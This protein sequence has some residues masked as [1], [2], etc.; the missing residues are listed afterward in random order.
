[1]P[2]WL[3]M[4]SAEEIEDPV[5][6]RCLAVGLVDISDSHAAALARKRQRAGAPHPVARTR[7]NDRFVRKSL[8]HVLSP[9]FT[10]LT[11]SAL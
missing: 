4:P 6:H 9:H 1:M 7:D 8:G 10:G 3:R 2:C 5:L 11:Q